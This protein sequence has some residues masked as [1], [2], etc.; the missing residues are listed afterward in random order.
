[1]II[2]E[3]TETGFRTDFTGEL[4]ELGNLRRAIRKELTEWG[5]ERLTD[6]AV[7]VIDE[8]LANVHEHSG[9]TGELNI[10]LG[11]DRLIVR[12]SDPDPTPPTPRTPAVTAESGRG[13]LL[14]DALTDHRETVI[15]D[16]GKTVVCTFRLDTEHPPVQP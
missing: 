1:M 8:L 16:M 5:L 10:A 4:A 7:L 14:V 3:G 15:T 12:V 2:T 13:L 9:G 11:K 6:D